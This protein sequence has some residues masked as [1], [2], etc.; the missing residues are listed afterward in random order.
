[1]ATEIP[2]LVNPAWS[3]ADEI[4]FPVLEKLQEFNWKI[5]LQRWV[6]LSD[7]QRFALLKLSYP[8]HENA[9]FPL[10]IKEF[11]LA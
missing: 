2:V 7:L 4:P 1:V 11:A 8:G 5:S 3:R 6:G 10:A 9:N